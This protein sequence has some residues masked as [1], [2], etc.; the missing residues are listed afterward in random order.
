[1]SV[2]RRFAV[3]PMT[4]AIKWILI[5]NGSLWLVMVILV[6]WLDFS[7]LVDQLA[8]KPDKVIV[9][10]TYWTPLT[11]MWIHDPTG[12]WHIL[13]NS[14]FLWMFGGVCEQHWGTSGFLRF[15][16]IC[17]IGAGLLIWLVGEL[18][19]SETPVVGASGAIYGVVVA[20]VFAFPNRVIYVFGLFPIKGKWFALIPIGFALVDFLLR[21]E[22]VS[23]TAHLG[24]MGIGALLVT[25]YWRPRK[26]Y[27]RIRYWQMRRK[28]RVVEDANKR[29]P[30]PDGGYW[31]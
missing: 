10:H 3:W 26:L 5:V 7:W 18:V 6:N 23:H 11:Y 4:P 30:P 9:S 15:Y 20:W 29:K 24:G 22:G 21:G 14:L 8:I 12:L 28:I 13:L 16:L 31:H 27:N 2:R 1:M 19:D 25:G 17:G